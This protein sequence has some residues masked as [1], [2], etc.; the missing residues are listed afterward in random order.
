[1]KRDSHRYILPGYLLSLHAV[2]L[3]PLLLGTSHLSPVDGGHYANSTTS[4]L[5]LDVDVS[6]EED[7]APPSRW[8]RLHTH[9]SIPLAI[10][11]FLLI[12]YTKKLLGFIPLPTDERRARLAWWIENAVLFGSG[13]LEE[14]WRWGVVR[15]L[16]HLLGGSGGWGGRGALW[17]YAKREPSLWEAVYLLGWTWSLVEASVSL[18]SPPSE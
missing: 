15:L 18:P 14:L 12:H 5:G 11:A 3:F 13:C 8:Q 2:L 10:A 6:V 7:Y 4:N 1:M 17:M 16:V 9:H